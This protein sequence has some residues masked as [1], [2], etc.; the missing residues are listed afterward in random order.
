MIQ[1]TSPCF[2]LLLITFIGDFMKPGAVLTCYQRE[3][4]THLFKLSG[5]LSSEGV[6]NIKNLE[7]SEQASYCTPNRDGE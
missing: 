6:L 1:I 4:E 2:S 3:I 7:I 5:A